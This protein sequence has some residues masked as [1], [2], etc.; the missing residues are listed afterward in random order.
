M[1]RE[2]EEKLRGR[3]QQGSKS[4]DENKSERDSERVVKDGRESGEGVTLQAVTKNLPT[5]TANDAWNTLSGMWCPE[6]IA[7]KYL[8]WLAGSH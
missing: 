3:K 2:R 1:I 8:I 7:A 6:P 4:E 5:F